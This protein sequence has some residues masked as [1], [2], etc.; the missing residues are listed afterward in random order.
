MKELAQIL[1]EHGSHNIN[2]ASEILST[3]IGK[4]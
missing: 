4:K 1:K 3:T 2:I